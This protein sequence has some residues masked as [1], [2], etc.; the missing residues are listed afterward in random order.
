VDIG[1]EFFFVCYRV[2][3]GTGRNTEIVGSK[4]IGSGGFRS[5]KEGGVERI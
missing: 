1:L 5:E 3:P 4:D 2:Q